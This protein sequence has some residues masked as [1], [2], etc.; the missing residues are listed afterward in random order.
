VATDVAPECV[1]LT[2]QNA[3]LNGVADRV[4]VRL[5]DGYAPVRG[6]A[7]DLV[8]SGPPQMPTPPD[9]ER[10]DWMALA[11]NGGVDGWAVLDRLITGAREHL[12]PGGRLVFSIFAFLG[13]R[14]GLAKLAAAGL[15][16]RVLAREIQP[17]PRLGYERL[18]HIRAHDV[19]QALAPGVPR[20]VERLLLEGRRAR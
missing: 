10:E 19:E 18:P 4:D 13:E 17:F 1:A 16:S 7:F 20:T 9:R 2:H 12:K 8:V 6:E 14:A 15:A 3:S 11:D 5:G